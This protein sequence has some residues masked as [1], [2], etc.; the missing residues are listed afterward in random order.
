MHN[1]INN[2]PAALLDSLDDEA[3]MKFQALAERRAAEIRQRQ[4]TSAIEEVSAKIKFFGLTLD[5][6]PML[7]V[8]ADPK[9][10][11]SITTT[12]KY[13]EPNSASHWSGNGTPKKAFREADAFDKANP[14]ATSKRMHQYLIPDDKAKDLSLRLKKNI[15]TV[16]GDVVKYA[17]LV[18]ESST[19]A[20]AST[21]A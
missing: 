3:F 13:Y 8:A 6:L 16:S 7:K 10:A 9:K 14:T 12:V 4:K 17:H 11:K 5:D 1:E 21:S 20:Q 2:N 15:R 19:Y 18:A